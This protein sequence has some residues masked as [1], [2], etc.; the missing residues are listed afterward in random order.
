MKRSFLTLF[1]FTL[2]FFGC[3]KEPVFVEIEYVKFNHQLFEEN[4]KMEELIKK[5]S[6]EFGATPREMLLEAGYNEEQTQ[7]VL[8]KLNL[9]VALSKDHTVHGIAY[10]TK[11]PLGESVVASGLL[12]CPQN[13]LPKGV[14]FVYPLLKTKGNSGTDVRFSL[15]ALLAISGDYICMIPDGI[16]QGI[17]SNQPI[18]I[19]Q[20][21]NLAETG[22]DFYLAAREFIYNRHHYK[23]PK[24][25]YLLG[26]SL[27]GSAIWSMARYLT[28]HKEFGIGVKD[29]FVGGGPYYPD[30][31]MKNIFESR[32]SNYASIPF[33]L[34]SLNYYENLNIDFTK[35]FKGKLLD[36]FPSLCDGH[37]GLKDVTSYI[38]TD[39]N[40][41]LDKDFLQNEENQYRQ[42]IMDALE[43]NSIPN[44]WLPE[45]KVHLYNCYNDL[46]VPSICGDKLYEYLRE[47]NANVEYIH[48]D[49]THEK[50]IIRMMIDFYKHLYPDNP[51]NLPKLY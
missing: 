33:I 17:S 1:V 43:K 15:E 20:H 38:G 32:N 22:T 48:E 36:E 8:E 47:V 29:I 11:D 35:I 25:I 5:A 26:Y 30:L 9:Y 2:S 45:V 41:Y 7:Q 39:L 16:G 12:Y 44:D 19:I 40:D 28:I 18:S 34:W 50:M 51:Y 49:I 21:D 46:Y 4:V 3:E 10:N 14:I 37:K 31:F 13:R 6:R 42:L 23:L 24:N 27:G